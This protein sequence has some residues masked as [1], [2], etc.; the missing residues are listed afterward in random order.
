MDA[1]IKSPFPAG[2]QAGALSWMGE[3]S[4]EGFLGGF[5]DGFLARFMDGLLD[6]FCD[7]FWVHSWMDSLVPRTQCLLKSPLDPP[8]PKASPFP[9]LWKISQT[10]P[11]PCSTPVLHQGLNPD[12]NPRCYPDFCHP[13]SSPNA[14][15]AEQQSRTQPGQCQA[16]R[17]PSSTRVK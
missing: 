2:I 17:R 5:L 16:L 7:G 10:P 8:I 13:F 9:N 15:L 12:G 4:L 1:G 3:G 11:A 14:F 6:G